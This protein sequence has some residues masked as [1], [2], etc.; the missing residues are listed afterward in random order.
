MAFKVLRAD[1]EYISRVKPLT[2]RLCPTWVPIADDELDGE[3][4]QI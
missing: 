3:G 1:T 2:M 4:R